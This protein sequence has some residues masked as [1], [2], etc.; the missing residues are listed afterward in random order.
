MLREGL[1]TNLAIAQQL[2][3]IGTIYI[4][5]HQDCGAFKTFLPKSG[6]PSKLGRDNN[7]EKEI[8][9]RALLIA[10]EK[11]RKI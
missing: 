5:N 11:L 9:L 10:K 2:S 6:Y 1:L 7:A 4:I 8:H 3:E